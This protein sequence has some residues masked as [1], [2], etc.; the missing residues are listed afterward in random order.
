MSCTFGGYPPPF[1]TMTFKGKL[2]S[3]DSVTANTSVRTDAEK[4]FGDYICHAKN[5]YGIKNQ[6]VTLKQVGE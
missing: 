1:V 5:D 3:N 6:T 4:K 2:M